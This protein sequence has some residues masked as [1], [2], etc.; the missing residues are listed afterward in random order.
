MRGKRKKLPLDVQRR[1]RKKKT[2]RLVTVK[3]GRFY[4]EEQHFS[5]AFKSADPW[6]E[7][8]VYQ[9]HNSRSC[10]CIVGCFVSPPLSL[11]LS[12]TNHRLCSIHSDNLDPQRL[13]AVWCLSSGAVFQLEAPE[14]QAAH[15]LSSTGTWTH[16]WARGAFRFRLIQSRE[17]SGVRT[18]RVTMW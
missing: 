11:S 18:E 1:G 4:A 14:T 7:L 9:L 16:L 3:L 13:S 17:R 6:M 12:V 8:R 10:T 2:P 5:P 15:Q